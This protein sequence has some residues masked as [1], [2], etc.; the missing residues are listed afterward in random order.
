MK[1][2]FHALRIVRSLLHTL[3]FKALGSHFDGI[4]RLSI[5]CRQAPRF[6]L[7]VIRLLWYLPKFQQQ[8]CRSACQCKADAITLFHILAFFEISEHLM[9]RRHM[10]WWSPYVPSCT[11]NKIF[12]THLL[13][14][15]YIVSF[16]KFVYIMLVVIPHLPRITESV[17]CCIKITWWRQ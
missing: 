16:S 3:S 2:S 12:S 6:M 9:I 5:R 7:R 17:F 11:W 15:A 8:W 1:W 10:Q 14:I 4:R 13:Y